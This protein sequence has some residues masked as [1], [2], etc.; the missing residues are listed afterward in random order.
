MSMLLIQITSI[1]LL[2]TRAIVQ[3]EI[4]DIGCR[5]VQKMGPRKPALTSPGRLPQ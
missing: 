1:F 3:H 4:R 2:D 5:G